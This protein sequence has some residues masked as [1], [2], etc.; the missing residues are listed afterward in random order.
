MLF[1]QGEMASGG[2][3]RLWWLEAWV[4][5]LADLGIA[6]LPAQRAAGME[7]AAA[8]RYARG[9]RLALEDHLFPACAGSGHRN[10]R[11]ESSRIGVEGRTDDLRGRTDLDDTPEV[12]DRDPVGEDPGER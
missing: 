11:H 8:G 12:E 5:R 7:P 1:L 9:R 3:V 2:M 10:D 4:D 6:K